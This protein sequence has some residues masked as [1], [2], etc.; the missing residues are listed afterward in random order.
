ML[1]E[2]IPPNGLSQNMSS[3]P[4]APWSPGYPLERST[5]S[6]SPCSRSNPIGL[7]L[8]QV[9]EVINGLP[10]IDHNR[11]KQSPRCGKHINSAHLPAHGIIPFLESM[12]L[13]NG[14]LCE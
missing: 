2:A 5:W 3:F 7:G 10:G 12:P 9:D 13:I 6:S 4:T 14:P 1:K 8:R 11:E